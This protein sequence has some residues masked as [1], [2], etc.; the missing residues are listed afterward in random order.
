MRPGVRALLLLF[1]ILLGA[2]RAKAPYEGRGVAELERMLRD[3]NP[4]VQA[5]GAYGLSRL[6]SEARSA[7]PALIAALKKES[8]V[9]QNAALALGQIGP[10]ARDAV[11]ALC[12]ALGDSEWTVRRHAALALGHIGPQARQAIPA[13]HKLSRDLDPLV[14]QAAKTALQQIRDGERTDKKSGK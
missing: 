6:G 12:E 13:L 3:A 8:L 1:L 10:D 2:C 14:R 5:Q 7:V 11:P 9:R 4:A